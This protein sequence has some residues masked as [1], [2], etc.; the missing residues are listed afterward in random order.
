M[1]HVASIPANER[2]ESSPNLR[3]AQS[4]LQTEGV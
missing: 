1:M 4:T 3:N 2:I